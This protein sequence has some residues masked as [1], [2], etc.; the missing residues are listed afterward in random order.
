MRGGLSGLLHQLEVRG[1]ERRQGLDLAVAAAAAHWKVVV[2]VVVEQ[3]EQVGRWDESGA[4]AAEA[5]GVNSVLVFCSE[6]EEAE[7]G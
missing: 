2:V 7:E 6:A 3:V 1:A 4:E 5:E